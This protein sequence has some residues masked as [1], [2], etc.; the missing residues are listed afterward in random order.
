M[1]AFNIIYSIVIAVAVIPWLGFLF[2]L[3]ALLSYY[4][5]SRASVAIRESVRL[6]ATIK[7]PL[8]SF[9]TESISGQSTIRAFKRTDDFIKNNNK[10]LD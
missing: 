1:L 7:S 3:V 2:P 9:L 8:L 6:A 4:M 10:I 5:V